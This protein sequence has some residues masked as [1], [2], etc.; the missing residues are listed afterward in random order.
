MKISEA[1]RDFAD[2]IDRGAGE[3]ARPAATR[4]VVVLRRGDRPL[5]LK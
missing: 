2:E 3:R 4:T 5:V 1:G